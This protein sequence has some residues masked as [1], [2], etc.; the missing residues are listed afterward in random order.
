[1]T[2]RPRSRPPAVTLGEGNTPLVAS[3]AVA[4]ANGA[5]RLFFKLETCN[6]SGSYKDR[7]ISAE[8]ARILGEGAGTCVATSS[9]NTGSALAAYCARYGLRCFVF[10]NENAP[11]GKLAQMQA[12]GATVIRIPG[13]ITDFRVTSNVFGT[14]TNFSREHRVPLI[15]S[16]FRYC[17]EGMRSVQRI[18]AEILARETP[19]H[20]FV[21]VGGGGLYSAI[22][23]GFQES[24]Q[25][26]PK[27]H[28]VQ[29]EGC[30]TTVASFLR[31]TNEIRSVNSTTRI[32]GLSVPS[33]ID[34]GRALLKL[35][36]CEGQGIPVSDEE[37]FSAQRMLLEKEG[38]CGEPAGATALAGWLS[39]RRSG[40]V[41]DDEASVCLVTGHGFKDPASIEDAARRHPSA[42][43]ESDDL[44]D[45]LSE[46]LSGC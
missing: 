43:V 25:R 7:F 9:G 1:M 10:V 42:T 11:T 46:V 31:G 3:V 37:V 15:V 30:L 26:V 23:Q 40:I 44:D 17:P 32:S 39:A 20:V 29:P 38:I 6:P 21:P 8:I 13:F 27:V 12:H 22:V 19:D 36:E 24:G 33:D 41:G 45:V 34:A 28:A 14:L 16:A 2:A 35:R 4:P 18:A 5:S